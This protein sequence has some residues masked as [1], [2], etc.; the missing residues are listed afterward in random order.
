[1]RAALGK[2]FVPVAPGKVFCTCAP[3]Q[4]CAQALDTRAPGP[5]TAP[6]KTFVPIAVAPSWGA[7]QR[8]YPARVRGRRA[9][10]TLFATRRGRKAMGV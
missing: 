4:A 1:M 2:A 7:P 3:L 10:E 6:G 5:P 8:A 9:A